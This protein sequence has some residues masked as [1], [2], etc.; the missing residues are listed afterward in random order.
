MQCG[1]ARCAVLRCSALCCTALCCAA[2]CCA[3]HFQDETCQCISTKHTCTV[4]DLHSALCRTHLSRKS[5]LRMCSAA[6]PICCARRAMPIYIVATTNQNHLP[7]HITMS[8]PIFSIMSASEE[9]LQGTFPG[10]R[11]NIRVDI[12]IQRLLNI[13]VVTIVVVILLIVL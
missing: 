11:E 9:Q 7:Y 3:V 5:D 12:L 1:D 4:G 13:I 6:Y 10:R 2:R 8:K